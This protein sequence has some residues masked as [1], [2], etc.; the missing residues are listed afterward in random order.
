MRLSIGHLML[1]VLIL[2]KLTSMFF[3]CVLFVEFPKFFGPKRHFTFWLSVIVFRFSSV[4]SHPLVT[5]VE[6]PFITISGFRR[7]VNE[8]FALLGCYAA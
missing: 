7:F 8:L 5:N 3:F 6:V 4:F 2:L 1:Y